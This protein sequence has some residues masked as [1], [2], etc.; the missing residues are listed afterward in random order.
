M[1]TPSPLPAG[2]AIVTGGA[3]GIGH[4]IALRLAGKGWHVAVADCDLARAEETSHQIRATGGQAEAYHLDVARADCWEQLLEQLQPT[5]PRLDLLVNAAGNLLIGPV[6]QTSPADIAR[7]VEVNLLGTMLGCRFCLPW[8]IDSAKQRVTPGSGLL[9][10]ASI[11]AQVSPPGFATY[12][13]TKAGIIAWTE[14]LRGELA[15]WGLQA[16]VALPGV[17]PTRLFERTS[18]PAPEWRQMCDRYLAGAELTPDQVARAALAGI[19]QGQLYVVVGRR[20]KWYA[21]LKRLAPAWLIDKVGRLANDRMESSDVP[22]LAI[23]GD[24]PSP[25]PCP[26]HNETL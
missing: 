22:P 13:A 21:R 4:A 20:A 14:S 17:T 16:T 12:N 15:A 2:W 1:R 11:F 3:S 24:P 6:H 10:F 19:S 18:Y 25:L 23:V 8:L 5:W 7:L 26:S 9:N